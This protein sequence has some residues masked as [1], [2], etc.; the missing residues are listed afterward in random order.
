M[1]FFNSGDSK[2][3]L[4]AIVVVL[5]IQGPVMPHRFTEGLD[6]QIE[7]LAS[8]DPQSLDPLFLIFLTLDDTHSLLVNVIQ[9]FFV[10]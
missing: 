1:C 7:L 10:F 2:N 8:I 9:L 4:I 5:E 6:E 3:S